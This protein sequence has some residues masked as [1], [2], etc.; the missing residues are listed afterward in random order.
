MHQHRFSSVIAISFIVFTDILVVCH[1]CMRPSSGSQLNYIINH[2][3]FRVT[4]LWWCDYASFTTSVIIPQNLKL[5]VQ[6]RIET[7]GCV[8]LEIGRCAGWTCVRVYLVIADWDSLGQIIEQTETANEWNISPLLDKI[9]E[10]RRNHLQH[11]NRMPCNRLLRILRDYRPTGRINQG[12]QWTR[13]SSRSVT[14]EWVNRWPNTMLAAWWWWW[15][16]W[17][18]W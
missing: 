11:V 18:W 9:Q 2:H 13:E 12:R 17:W 4:F 14:P 5:C 8:W 6:C 3:V 16:W 10:Y 1:N 7:T 15:W